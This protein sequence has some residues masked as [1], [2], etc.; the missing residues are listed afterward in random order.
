MK[1]EGKII[2]R[3][4]LAM[5]SKRTNETRL[6]RKQVKIVTGERGISPSEQTEKGKQS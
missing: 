3:Q 5:S 1:W 4:K 6:H 2:N